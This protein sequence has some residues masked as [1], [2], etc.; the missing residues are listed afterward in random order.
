MEISKRRERLLV[1]VILLANVLLAVLFSLGP[2]FEGPDEI[3]HVRYVRTLAQTLALPDPLAQ[4]RSEY[5]Q[6]PLYYLLNLP[7][8]LL[9]KMTDFEQIEARSN[10]YALFEVTVPGNDN[11]NQYF[12][13]SAEAFPYQDSPTALGVHLMRL[14][15]VAL[16][17]GS[18]LVSYAIFRL[19]WPD[20]ADLRL[21][22]LSLVA[23]WPQFLNGSGT[24]NNDN[25]LNLFSTLTLY[26][27][28]DQQRRGLNWRGAARLGLVAGG[29]LL[30]KVSALF[31]VFP[32]GIALL[33]GL[34]TMLL[35]AD[36]Q[37]RR[38]VLGRFLGFLAVVVVCLV[39]TCGWWFL[40]NA[41]QYGDAA[42]VST[43]LS[44][45]WSTEMIRRG[46][47]ALD[48][49]L[50][51]AAWSYGT[52]WARFSGGCIPVHE[53]MYTAFNVLLALALTGAA[54]KIIRQGMRLV[55]RPKI[56]AAQITA[57]LSATG[58]GLIVVTFALAWL[59]ALL[60]YA[61]TAW[62]GNQGRYLLPALAVWGIIGAYGVD[63][64]I[65]RRLRQPV[66]LTLALGLGLIAA[67]AVLVYFL[68]AY[69]PL[70]VPAIIEHPLEL[71]F[72]DKAEL[73]GVSPAIVEARPGETVQ[74][75]LYWR[76]LSP[77]TPL[78]GAYLHSVESALVRRN[79]MPATGNLVSS[80]WQP[81]QTWAESYMVSIP[82]DTPTQTTYTLVAGLF[83]LATKEALP[84][85]N[86][87][88]QPVT[89]IVGQLAIHGL[90][91]TSTTPGIIYRFGDNI[92]LNLSPVTRD[93]EGVHLCLT[94]YPLAR[95]KSD[96]RLF[97]H[98]L[99][100]E[101]SLIHQVDTPP[102]QGKYPTYVWA[103]GESIADCL[104]LDARKL[105]GDDWSIELGLFDPTTMGRLPIQKSD[106]AAL[107]NAAINVSLR[108]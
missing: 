95:I 56:D 11:K 57:L 16:G 4:N 54:V 70:P 87:D 88:G 28:L 58:T 67:I 48:V 71:R 43:L 33:I 107:P 20:R 6:A 77:V 108:R 52:F 37:T 98:V 41:I 83:D 93:D 32:I 18:V 3:E 10:P 34:L 59:A 97:V 90:P 72:A 36:Q 55:K 104:T 68:P 30:S 79:S 27:L 65:I 99:A 9:I 62:S 21:I 81:G 75:T 40:R 53:A 12:H 24:V 14:L 23:F 102:K 38:L 94:W 84:A 5:H 7:I 39:V 25:L 101:G 8:A 105:S 26:V 106:G 64:W 69:R 49:G 17:A 47:I 96:Y 50:T 19:L 1:A 13:T 63:T 15:S 103:N 42:L 73:I 86:V 76:A 92:G 2:I 45:T 29:A 46:Q 74:I 85:T 89:P 78:V 22:A 100:A 61:S 66:M 35:K 31:L 82:A 91:G 60:Y 80:E 51:R 44:K